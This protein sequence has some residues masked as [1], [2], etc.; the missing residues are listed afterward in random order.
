MQECALCRLQVSDDWLASWSWSEHRVG[1]LGVFLTVTALVR[2]LKLARAHVHES[3]GTLPWADLDSIVGLGA[4]QC[5]SVESW[6]VSC[7]DCLIRMA[8]AGVGSWPG[9]QWGDSCRPARAPRLCSHLCYPGR[10]GHEQWCFPVPLTME[11]VQA[12]PSSFSRL[13][14]DYVDFLHLLLVAL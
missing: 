1:G 13:Q 14:V 9:V 2:Q 8:G 3:R 11:K 12:I 6:G 10:V 4:G 5:R 7:W